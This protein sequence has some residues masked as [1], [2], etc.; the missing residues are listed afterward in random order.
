MSHTAFTYHLI[1]G[2]YRRLAVIDQDH[3]KEL[4]KFIYRLSTERGVLI[5]RIG[6]MPDHVHILCDI[7]AKLAVA[8]YVRIVKGETSKFMRANRNFP[9]WTAW[10]E[11]YG[12]FTVD[13]SLREVRKNYIM[14]QKQHHATTSFD[15]EYAALLA[16]AGISDD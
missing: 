3:E 14:N 9:N 16:E 6:G 4:Y 10:A 11:G 8:D 5:R 1:F 2:T 7:P 12:G 13:A 15:D